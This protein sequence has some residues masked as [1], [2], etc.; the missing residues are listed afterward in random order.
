[1]L[2]FLFLDLTSMMMECSDLNAPQKA[3]GFIKPSLNEVHRHHKHVKVN[4]HQ[5]DHSRRWTNAEG[6]E[7]LFQVPGEFKFRVEK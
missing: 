7:G 2:S 1:M 6:L 3:K 4:Y 5:S